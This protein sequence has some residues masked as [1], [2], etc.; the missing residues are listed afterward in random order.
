MADG[1][2]VAARSEV[3]VQGG[4]FRHLADWADSR[5]GF[6]LRVDSAIG[7]VFLHRPGVEGSLSVGLSKVVV[8]EPGCPVVLEADLHP[9]ATATSRRRGAQAVGRCPAAREVGPLPA[10]CLYSEV[11][12]WG[13]MEAA[14]GGSQVKGDWA[15]TAM[16]E[17]ARGAHSA[18]E[19][20]GSSRARG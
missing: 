7:S 13:A 19:R 2:P 5:A 10:G 8:Q 14:M 16:D 20:S 17:K 1:F 3:V 15:S 6:P 12:F 11:P 4:G 9:V 18:G